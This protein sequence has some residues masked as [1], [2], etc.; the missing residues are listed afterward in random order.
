MRVFLVEVSAGGFG[1][2]KPFV[3]FC[4]C[5][6]QVVGLSVQLL[7]KNKSCSIP[8]FAGAVGWW[9]RGPGGV[10][11]E[12]LLGAAVL[13]VL[14]CVCSAGVFYSAFAPLILLWRSGLGLGGVCSCRKIQ[15]DLGKIPFLF[16]FWLVC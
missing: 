9:E 10:L 13:S 2:G 11:G 1:G 12:K 6:S 7:Q 14:G 3:L 16:A 4:S 5:K 8:C 15:C